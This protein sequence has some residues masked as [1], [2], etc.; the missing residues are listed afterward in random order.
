M[1]SCEKVPRRTADKAYSRDWQV[2]GMDRQRGRAGGGKGQAV[3]TSMQRECGARG[4]NGGGQGGGGQ[5]EGLAGG[6]GSQAVGMGG[7]QSH[8]LRAGKKLVG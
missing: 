8:T 2:V 3:E 4:R 5:A 1:T 7:T 6:V